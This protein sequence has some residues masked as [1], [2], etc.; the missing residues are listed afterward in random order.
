MQVR[1]ELGP[2]DPYFSKL[3]DAMAVWIAAWQELNPAGGSGPVP[4]PVKAQGNG[5][6][7]A[8]AVHANGATK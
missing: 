7:S 8:P 4:A 5:P 6:T 1:E 3:A 2:L